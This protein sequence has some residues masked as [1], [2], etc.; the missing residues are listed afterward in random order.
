MCL[1]VRV[2]DSETKS[3][4][5]LYSGDKK[6]IR[7]YTCTLPSELWCKIQ[8]LLHIRIPPLVLLASELCYVARLHSLHPITQ[9]R[10][11]AGNQMR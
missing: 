9:R 8:A 11:K 1:F 6:K 5:N 7:D 2:R 3:Q 4:L 10:K